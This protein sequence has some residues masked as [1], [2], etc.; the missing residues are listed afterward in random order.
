MGKLT[1]LILVAPKR[2]EEFCDLSSSVA[3]SVRTYV[4]TRDKPKTQK[5]RALRAAS[6]SRLC[7]CCTP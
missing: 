7:G 1:G 4:S 2:R 3:R 5:N 6:V